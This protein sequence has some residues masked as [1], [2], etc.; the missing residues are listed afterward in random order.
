M[1]FQLSKAFIE[2][3]VRFRKSLHQHPELSG[4]EQST[5]RL[6]LDFLGKQS[7]A[8][9]F[10]N[11]GG[12]GLA[13]MYDSKAQGPTTLFRCELDA[14]PIQ[15]TNTFSHKSKSEGVSHKCGHDGHMTIIAGLGKLL[16]EKGPQK[17]KV[18]LLFQPAEETG[19]GATAVLNDSQFA[20]LRPDYCYALHNV[21]QLHQGTI[22][23]KSGTFAAA[24]RGIIIKLYGATAHAA[25][26]ENGINPAKAMAQIIQYLEE[27]PSLTDFQQLTL[28]TVVQ[29]SLGKI[30]F[31]VSPGYAEVRATLRAYL[32]EDIIKLIKT[33]EK[34]ISTIG[35]CENLK[36]NIEYAEVFPE[37]ANH[38]AAVSI[39]EQCAKAANIPLVP[40]DEPFKWSEDFGHFLLKY[41]GAIFALGAGENVP[42]LHNH[43]YDFPDAITSTGVLMFLQLI[44]HHN[45]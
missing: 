8:K 9:V 34:T 35:Q 11:L 43:D 39:V 2:T 6:I 20:A 10:R 38:E 36:V 25:E 15:E 14:L 7:T 37:T 32:E 33:I 29:A 40:L 45:G 31:G 18:V 30:A 1:A 3:L 4:Q 17:G 41:K 19:T 21:P 26:P 27:A 24:S 5:P 22:Y 42:K 13:I 23:V 16:Q 12:N 28:V 44:Q